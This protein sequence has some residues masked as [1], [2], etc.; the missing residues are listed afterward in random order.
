MIKASDFA[1]EPTTGLDPR[2]KK[3]IQEFTRQ[4]RES[5]DDGGISA[6]DAP[7]GLR[8]LVPKGDE[9]PSLQEG[10]E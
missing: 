1:D 9:E 8:R 7:E 4:P 5:L 3:G 10:E 6:I 2:S